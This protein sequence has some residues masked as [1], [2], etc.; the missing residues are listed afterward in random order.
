MNILITDADNL[1]DKIVSPNGL[2]D[3]TVISDNGRIRPCV[4][5]FSCWVKT[6]GECVIKDGYENMGTLLAK[7]SRLFVLSECFYGSYGPFVH[8]VMD[9]SIPYLTPYFKTINGE[10]HH[11]N[12]YDN[13]IEFT[14]FFYGDI[15][16]RE[17]KTAEKL[18]KANGVNIFV[19]KTEVFFFE[20]L[21]DVK[22]RL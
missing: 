7:C 20:R 5:C 10:T 19:K 16:E 9:R 13:E 2:A 8:N 17:K 11:L 18:V 1:E 6:P 15:T 21:T 12:R 14:V 3:F 4:C 22:V